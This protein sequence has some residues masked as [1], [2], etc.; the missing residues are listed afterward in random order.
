LQEPAI[1]TNRYILASRDWMPIYPT[2]YW[3]L[4]K[5]IRAI[6]LIKASIKTD[7]WEQLDFPSYD[8]IIVQ[9]KGEWGKLTIINMYNNCHNNKTI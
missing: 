8:I 4:D 5:S 7:S 6:M 9:L 2:P 3:E 1:D